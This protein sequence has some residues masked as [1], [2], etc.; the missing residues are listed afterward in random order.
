MLRRQPSQHAWTRRA[1]VRVRPLGTGRAG[2]RVGDFW[3]KAP[4]SA[5]GL[6][7]ASACQWASGVSSDLW[8]LSFAIC[9]QTSP[10][11]GSQLGRFEKWSRDGTA[12]C[13]MPTL[14][15][16]SS[17]PERG[18]AGGRETSIQSMTVALGVYAPPGWSVAHIQAPSVGIRGRLANPLSWTSGTGVRPWPARFLSSLAKA[19][20]GAA[21]YRLLLATDRLAR[22]EA[23][24][25]FAPDV[26]SVFNAMDRRARADRGP[27]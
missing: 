5:Q 2:L 26:S 3:A 27:Q 13:R 9:R 23:E 21:T 20:A 18:R 6:P 15:F 12:E 1:T 14:G 10:R 19:R 17:P 11:W 7:S 4:T 25:V 22:L 8:L 16:W 24:L